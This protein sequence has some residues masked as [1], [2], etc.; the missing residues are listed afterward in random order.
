MSRLEAMEGPEMSPTVFVKGSKIDLKNH[1]FNG[2]RD[3][4]I[5]YNSDE[6][7]AEQLEGKVIVLHF[8][9]LYPQES[10]RWTNTAH[11]AEVYTELLSHAP[12]RPFEVVVVPLPSAPKAGDKVNVCDLEEKLERVKNLKLKMLIGREAVFTHDLIFQKVSFSDIDVG[13]P[14][15]VFSAPDNHMGY[16]KFQRMLMDTYL[17]RKYTSVEFEV[18]QIGGWD[19][20]T[21]P[22][23]KM[24]HSYS[25]FD[26][27]YNNV[28][29]RFSDVLHYKGYGV[30]VFD[31]DGKV[32]RA[33]INPGIFD[34]EAADFPFC[35]ASMEEE[36]NRSSRTRVNCTFKFKQE[37]WVRL[38]WVLMER[39][40][41]Q[42]MRSVVLGRV[43]IMTRH[44][45]AARETCARTG[46]L[47]MLRRTFGLQ[48]PPKLENP[49]QRFVLLAVQAILEICRK[50]GVTEQPGENSGGDR[51][52]MVTVVEP[53]N[54]D[55]FNERR[56]QEFVEIGTD[57]LSITDP[58][59]RRVADPIT[60]RPKSD[61]SA[62]DYTMTESQSDD[63]NDP[64][65]LILA[66]SARQTR[67][68]L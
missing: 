59:R 21:V 6:V 18:I 22:W 61:L 64:N 53:K 67:Q 4:L 34:F 68:T 48:I 25:W 1:L 32:A 63:T 47:T 41:L 14:I 10:W 31:R 3:Y 55:I 16:M 37:E 20:E 62:E 8:V 29:K 9:L 17:E 38:G 15:I 39:A 49:V 23:L 44:L 13:K 57:G 30:F 35:G 36:V 33:T 54:L 65:N 50:S 7:K 12:P 11:L 66:G 42:Q 46:L 2:D 56:E 58:K 5:K 52:K 28:I 51:T 60:D 19:G 26:S 45:T 43:Q 24:P 27:V 40:C